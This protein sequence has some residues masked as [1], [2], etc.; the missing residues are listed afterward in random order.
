MQVTEI[1]FTGYSVANMKRAKAFYEGVLGLKK[2]RG[3]GQHEG[4]DQW[5][6]YDIGAGC[7]PLNSGGGKEWPPGSTGVAIALEVGDFDAAI[8]KLRTST[9]VT[10]TSI[11]SQ[12]PPSCVPHKPRN[13]HRS[14]FQRACDVV[15]DFHLRRQ[16]C[17]R[18]HGGR[19]TGD[20][21]TDQ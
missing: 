16:W 13:E 21:R 19:R 6:E 8:G 18:L 2:S 9:R 12:P 20:C 1:A 7:L 10:A 5:A 14:R 17:P 11:S 3:F 15:D 4:E